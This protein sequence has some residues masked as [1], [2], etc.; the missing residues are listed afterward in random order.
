M[1]AGRA[2]KG[3]RAGLY[4]FGE[5]GLLT[6]GL[7]A[8]GWVALSVVGLHGSSLVGALVFVGAFIVGFVL[9]VLLAFL[10]Y[11]ALGRSSSFVTDVRGSI[12]LSRGGISRGLW[13]F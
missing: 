4:V 3:C 1:A 9:S 13:P 2:E 6:L 8:A 10:E 7:G 11:A 5:V 12:W